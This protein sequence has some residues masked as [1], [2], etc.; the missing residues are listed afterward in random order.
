[1]SCVLQY[2]VL[3]VQAMIMSFAAVAVAPIQHVTQHRPPAR[4]TTVPNLVMVALGAAFVCL[5]QVLVSVLLHSCSWFH[6]GTGGT[7]QVEQVPALYAHMQKCCLP[8][9]QHHVACFAALCGALCDQPCCLES[10]PAEYLNALPL[11]QPY[12]ELT[13]IQAT[14]RSSSVCDLSMPCI[15]AVLP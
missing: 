15:R 4:I 8:G 14:Q 10:G 13:C 11:S 6:G 7:Y 12:R 1:M 2:G 5:S 9:L 3:D